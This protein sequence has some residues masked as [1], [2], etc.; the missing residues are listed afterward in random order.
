MLKIFDFSVA[1]RRAPARPRARKWAAIQTTS[2]QM[3]VHW[4]VAKWVVLRFHRLVRMQ[5][6]AFMIYF[7]KVQKKF[8]PEG[9]ST[10]L[11]L[12][13]TLAAGDMHEVWF[14]KHMLGDSMW[15]G[16]GKQRCW[17]NEWLRN[18]M[19]QGARLCNY[20]RDN[21]EIHQLRQSNCSTLTTLIAEAFPNFRFG[22]ISRDFGQVP[23]ATCVD[24]LVANSCSKVSCEANFF[25]NDGF[26]DN[27]PLVF[28]SFAKKVFFSREKGKKKGTSLE[29]EAKLPSLLMGFQNSAP[30]P[31]AVKLDVPMSPR[32]SVTCQNIRQNTSCLRWF[33]H[34]RDAQVQIVA[35]PASV[36]WS[37][38]AI[39]QDTMT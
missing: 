37:N 30:F 18:E 26:P 4:M 17:S 24:C 2:I 32:A 34:S 21:D 39:R 12:L 31:K 7:R 5:S 15:S 13:N 27:G 33:G 6:Y 19:R 14:S 35:H 1:S 22:G 28:C 36:S 11:A 25:D 8:Q 3:R 10:T 23:H 20:A 29:R 9:P 38:Q 16:L